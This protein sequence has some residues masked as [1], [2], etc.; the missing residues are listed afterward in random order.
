MS[1]LTYQILIGLSILLTGYF[2]NS[3]TLELVT[4]GWFVWTLTNIFTPWLMFL[5]MGTVGIS[6]LVANSYTR[7]AAQEI[8]GKE[9]TQAPNIIPGDMRDREIFPAYVLRIFR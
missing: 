6:W 5:Q 9:I 3:K 4:G 7:K 2:T 1:V 8:S